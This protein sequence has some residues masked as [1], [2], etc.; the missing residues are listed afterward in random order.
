MQR[1]LTRGPRNISVELLHDLDDRIAWLRQQLDELDPDA[2]S[3]LML[4][5]RFEMSMRQIG[6][7][8]GLRNGA[9]DGRMNRTIARLRVQAKEKF[10]E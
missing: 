3:L 2:G 1:D 6:S 10:H 4:R 7:I 9:V 5:H 8:V